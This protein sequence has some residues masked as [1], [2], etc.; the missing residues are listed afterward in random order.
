MALP[1]RMSKY[2]PSPLLK[3]HPRLR[4]LLEPHQP[5]A[6]FTKAAT[7]C[8]LVSVAMTFYLFV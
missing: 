1:Q 3:H 2:N 5:V 6:H 7:T 8:L 4:H